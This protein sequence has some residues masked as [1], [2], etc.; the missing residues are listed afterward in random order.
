MPRN[1]TP[2]TVP[3]R[4][5]SPPVKAVPPMS[6][7]AITLSIRFGSTCG[8]AA[9]RRPVCTTQASPAE[10]PEMAYTATST[11]G[12][13]MPVSLAASGFDPT[14]YTERPKCVKWRTKAPMP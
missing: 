6:T 4:P 3:S 12:T 2:I 11:A 1:R 7:A 5:P 13:L 8:L 10:R 14:A 9:V